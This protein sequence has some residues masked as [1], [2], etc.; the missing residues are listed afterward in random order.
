MNTKVLENNNLGLALNY[1]DGVKKT[2][3]VFLAKQIMQ[4]LGY[5]GGNKALAYYELIEN[6]DKITL[7]KKEH[8]SFFNQLGKMNLLG[9]RSG[10]IIMLYESGVWKLI[11]QSKKPIGIK[12]RNWLAREVLP[13]IRREGKY[14]VTE[15]EQNPF[16]YLHDFTETSKQIENSK[17]VAAKAKINHLQYS[18]V[19]NKIHKLVTGKTA[20]EI[21]FMFKSKESARELLR[22]NF[23]E[24]ACTEAVIDELFTKF[25][26]SFNEIE[27]SN[28]HRT[29]PPAFQSLYNLGIEFNI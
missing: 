2:E 1:W 8:P 15:S 24:L 25:N 19:Y 23:P 3:R 29:L 11:M 5:K 4:Q 16:S 9:A 18:D 27:K 22:K 17:N 14:N 7:T 21:K 13:T 26:K 20:K 10:S 6:I 12:T 28:A